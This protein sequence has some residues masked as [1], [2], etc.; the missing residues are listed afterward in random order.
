MLW[1]AEF[2]RAGLV[3]EC[4]SQ[5]SLSEYS[6]LQSFSLSR[7]RIFQRFLSVFLSQSQPQPQPQPPSWLNSRGSHA[8]RAPLDAR[9][10]TGAPAKALTCL[11]IM[12]GTSFYDLGSPFDGTPFYGLGTPFDGTP[13]D[14]LGTPFE[15]ATF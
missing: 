10:Q 11:A 6:V 5:K 13:F 3:T 14:R 7:G 9:R 2:F 12:S 15:G 1:V 8:Y 4:L